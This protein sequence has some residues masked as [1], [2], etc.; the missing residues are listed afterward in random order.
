MRRTFIYF[1]L[2]QSMAIW[3]SSCKGDDEP[4]SA[5][6]QEA[7]YDFVTLVESSADGSVFTM[8][9]NGDSPLIS[10]YSDADFSGIQS[11]KAGDRL[12]LC[13]GRIDGEVYTSGKINVYGYGQ[14]SSTDQ[15]LL[16]GNP[17]DYNGWKCPPMKVNSLWRTGHYINLDTRISLFQARRPE[18][19]VLVADEAT[20][21]SEYP[22]LHIYYENAEDNDGENLYRVYASFD[23]SEVWDKASCEGVTVSYPTADGSAS[24]TF[25]K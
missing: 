18:T 25:E 17:S 11:I 13:Y 9:R 2:I 14:L 15:N 21:E 23:I 10:Y 22:R 20:C 6:P 5:I 1:L 19:L 8:R 12:I 3:A 7:V 4:S 24:I 16:S